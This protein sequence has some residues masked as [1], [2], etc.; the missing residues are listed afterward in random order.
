[1]RIF[2]QVGGKYWSVPDDFW[3]WHLTFNSNIKSPAVGLFLVWSLLIMLINHTE[4]KNFS[5]NNTFLPNQDF[6]L[7][8]DAV[9]CC[10]HAI[11]ALLSVHCKSI[12]HIIIHIYIYIYIYIHDKPY[13]VNSSQRITTLLL[14]RGLSVPLDKTTP[15]RSRAPD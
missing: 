11:S 12:I 6:I 8:W 4:D 13:E 2:N 7:N 5:R 3:M 14:R 10:W 9:N 15:G 1:M